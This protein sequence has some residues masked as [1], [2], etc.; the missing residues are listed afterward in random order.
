[1]PGTFLFILKLRLAL[2]PKQFDDFTLNVSPTVNDAVYT[3][4]TIVS[5]VVKGVAK[6]LMV[7]PIGGV[8]IYKSALVILLMVYNLLSPGHPLFEPVITPGRPGIEERIASAL[9]TAALVPQELDAVTNKL[10]AEALA[11]KFTVILFVPCP[12]AMVEFA[13][14]AQVNVAPGIGLTEYGLPVEGLQKPV[15]PTIA[16]GEGV[17][18]TVTIIESFAATHAPAPSG[19]LVVKISL[20]DPAM[21]SLAD[22][23]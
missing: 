4:V 15:V 3:T 14:P 9:V 23:V 18:L 8:H 10:P 13:G 21:I 6:P 17:E 7:A 2:T 1:M 11:A 20:T 22:G 16:D 12:V 5:A 19:S